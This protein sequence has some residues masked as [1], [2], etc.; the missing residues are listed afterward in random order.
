MDMAGQVVVVVGLARSGVAA[1]R[2]LAKRGARVVATDTKGAGELEDEVLSLAKE[3]VRLEL[4]GHQEGTVLGADLVVVSPGVPWD[5]P[6]LKAARDKGTRVIGELELGSRF[7]EGPIAAITGTKGKSTTTAALGAILEEAGLSCRVGGNIGGAVTSLLDGASRETIFVL[8]VSSFQLEGTAS[9]HPKVSIFLN[10]TPDHLDRHGDYPSYAAAK[11]RIFE[12]QEPH[13]FAVVNR[14]FPEVLSFAR[15]GAAQI[16]TFSESGGDA[17][18]LGDE[19]IFVWAGRREVLFSR[20]SLQVKGSHLALDLLAAAVAARLLGAPQEALARALRAFG[21]REHVLEPVA[22]VRGVRFVN[23][24]KATNVDA[25]LKSLEAF[26]PYVIPILGG[27]FKGG[28]LSLLREPVRTRA[29]VVLAIGEAQAQ[30]AEALSGT[31]RVVACSSLE[32]AVS[33]AF[34]EAKSG[35]VVLLAPACAS[36]DMFVDYAARGKAFK[37]AVLKIAGG[38]A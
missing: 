18:F 14:D 11:A 23:D 7:I 31:V 29:R 24:S 27:R 16:V 2:F 10:L 36:F 9:F 26:P 17:F 21:G 19:A 28:D 25:A 33:R 12:N 32:E 8:E 22:E 3:G 38:G 30:I 5:L 13:D 37:A 4:G 1:A 6:I 20:S 15:R 35:D 34:Q